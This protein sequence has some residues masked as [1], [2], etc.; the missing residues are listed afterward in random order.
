MHTAIGSRSVSLTPQGPLFAAAQN[1]LDTGALL[2]NS[3]CQEAEMGERC[4]TGY[5]CSVANIQE[6]S[7]HLEQSWTRGL[8]VNNACSLTA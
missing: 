3:T 1:W 5:T 2:L 6:D 7:I 4:W 8:R